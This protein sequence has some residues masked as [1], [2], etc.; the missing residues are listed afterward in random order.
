MKKQI[1]R[2]IFVGGSAFA[3][4]FSIVSTVV[5]LGVQPLAANVIGFLVA[6]GVSYVGHRN[7]TFPSTSSAL[8]GAVMRFFAVVPI[9]PVMA[10]RLLVC[11][12]RS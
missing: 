12:R 4:H 1:V 10:G 2:F 3:V 8:H 11:L 9:Y 6:F 7:W 5:P